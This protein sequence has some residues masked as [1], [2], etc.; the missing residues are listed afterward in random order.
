MTQTQPS[1]HDNFQY[2]LP[3]KTRQCFKQ[4]QDRCD[5]LSLWLDRYIGYQSGW[6]FKEEQKIKFFQNIVKNYKIPNQII[7]ANYQR[8]QQFTKSF[9]AKSFTAS[10]EWRMVV[11]LGQTSILETSM[12]LDRITG[13]PIIPSSALKGLAAS[14]AMLCHLNT[15]DRNEAEKDPIFKAIFGTQETEGKVIFFD[16]VPTKTLKLEPDIMNNHYPDYYQS[17]STSAPTPYQNPIP[18]YFLTLGRGTQF[19]FAVAG[20]DNKVEQNLVTQAKEW[21]QN[22]LQEMGIGAKTAAGYGYLIIKE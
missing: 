18:V 11:G 10:P 3:P 2:P 19:A 20:K 22:G 4:K 14:C 1:N 7:D 17:T 5:N 12:T 8:W 13:I 21:L 9:D 15:T 6:K 16:A